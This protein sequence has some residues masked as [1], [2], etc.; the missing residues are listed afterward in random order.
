M[1]A[2]SCLGFTEY[3]PTKYEFR[4]KTVE[5][6]FFPF[7]IPQ[8]FEISELLV[9]VTDKVRKQ[10]PGKTLIRKN[11][12]ADGLNLSVSLS[13]S[14]EKTNLEQLCDLFNATQSDKDDC[15]ITDNGLKIRA[16]DIPDGKTTEELWQIF[17]IKSLTS[18]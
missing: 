6:A 18:R 17:K 15:F 3:Q 2:I 12:N 9:L 5:T 11:E 10:F 7:A 4:G 16:V 8:F 13:K 1:K 14:G